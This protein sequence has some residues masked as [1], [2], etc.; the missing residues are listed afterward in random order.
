[1]WYALTCKMT[2]LHS[3]NIRQHRK[4]V[5]TNVGA[6]EN[7]KIDLAI[8]RISTAQAIQDFQPYFILITSKAWQL[9]S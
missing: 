9:M 3:P 8:H 6:S 5:K 1:M 7:Y 4:Y 2:Q